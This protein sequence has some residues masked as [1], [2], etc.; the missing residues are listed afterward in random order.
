MS[1]DDTR[2]VP[3]FQANIAMNKPAVAKI[4]DENDYE[5]RQMIKNHDRGAA[6]Q[7]S[8]GIRLEGAVLISKGLGV[9]MDRSIK[10]LH[11]Q[12]M[13]GREAAVDDGKTGSIV[14][15]FGQQALA[16]VNDIYLGTLKAAGEY[17]VNQAGNDIRDGIKTA[18]PAVVERTVFVQPPDDYR[19]SNG[20]GDLGKP[21]FVRK[22]PGER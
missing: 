13:D 20:L 18:P 8:T 17:L 6:A 15:D 11:A 1:N 21:K 10:E 4:L 22:G 2:I 12:V 9:T 3:R 7:L 16:V 5:D 14:V 19:P